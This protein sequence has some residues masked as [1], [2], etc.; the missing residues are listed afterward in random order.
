LE[1]Y[2]TERRREAMTTTIDPI[3]VA[4]A[5]LEAAAK[6]MDT[7]RENATG[8]CSPRVAYSKAA[9]AIRAIDPAAI[10]AQVQ[11]VIK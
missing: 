7:R 10:V 3:A 6:E 1:Y 4:K 2:G 8:L 5:A 9:R 11:K